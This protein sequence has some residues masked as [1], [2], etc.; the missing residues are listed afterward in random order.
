[1]EA[2]MSV[3]LWIVGLLMIGG[4]IVLEGIKSVYLYIIKKIHIRYEYRI[5][6]AKIKIDRY[7]K[8]SNLLFDIVHWFENIV[9]NGKTDKDTD[10]MENILYKLKKLSFFSSIEVLEQINK[11]EKLIGK[12]HD[13]KS[14]K[15]L[16]KEIGMVALRMRQDIYTAQINSD[17]GL[18]D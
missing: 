18:I 9:V 16:K 17:W 5:Q 12:E 1:M 6:I 8:I 10:K 4:W 7:E 13:E 3:P 11:V 2:N 14:L 15:K